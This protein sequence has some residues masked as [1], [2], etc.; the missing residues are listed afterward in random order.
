MTRRHGITLWNNPCGNGWQGKVVGHETPDRVTLHFPRRIAFGLTPGASDLIGF[1]SVL[2]TPGMVGQRIA[3]FT[4]I[5]TKFG[6][7]ATTTDQ[8]TFLEHCQMFGAITGVARSVAAASK[9]MGLDNGD[10]GS[11][12]NI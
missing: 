11:D 7:E 6:Q 8:D 10:D 4:A 3:I 12:A 9:I 1:K 5:E 2:V